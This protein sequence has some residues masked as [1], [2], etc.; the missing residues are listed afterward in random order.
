MAE[1]FFTQSISLTTVQRRPG[2]VITDFLY[3]H[4]AKTAKSASGLRLGQ[5]PGN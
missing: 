1:G 2:E 4:I 3:P 5:E